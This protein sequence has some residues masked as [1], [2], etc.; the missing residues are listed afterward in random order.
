MIRIIP[1]IEVTEQ[2][3]T[4]ATFLVG[5]DIN[6]MVKREAFLVFLKENEDVT[7]AF[8][9]MIFSFRDYK[10]AIDSHRACLRGQEN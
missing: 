4:L 1:T 8:I 9:T 5:M 7:S 2:E 10:R 6:D 3:L